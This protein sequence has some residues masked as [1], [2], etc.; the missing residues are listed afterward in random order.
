MEMWIP[1]I[2][3]LLNSDKFM[4]VKNEMLFNLNKEKRKII[5]TTLRDRDMKKIDLDMFK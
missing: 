2:V 4:I 1:I 3:H 5:R